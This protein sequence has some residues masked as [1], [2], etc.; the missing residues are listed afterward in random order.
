[1]Y[2]VEV[3][4]SKLKVYWALGMWQGGDVYDLVPL[5]DMIEA[6]RR[7]KL[8]Q[9]L[10]QLWHMNHLFSLAANMDAT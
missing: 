3:A 6:L 9:Q 1:M 4:F 7:A 2:S 10:I 8:S 5:M